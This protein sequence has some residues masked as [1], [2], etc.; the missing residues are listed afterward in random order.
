MNKILNNKDAKTQRSWS[1]SSSLFPLR[2]FAS[3]LFICL[4]LG[5]SGQT[6]TP[7]LFPLI[8]MFGSAQY[9]TPFTIQTTNTSTTD[10]S[11]LYVGQA[12]TITPQGTNPVVLL[13]PNTYQLIF[14]DGLFSVPFTVPAS[15]NTL[16]V[17]TLITN[18]LTSN[19]NWNGSFALGLPVGGSNTA[20]PVNGLGL[21]A[22]GLLTEAAWPSGGGGGGGAGT[23]T[24]AIGT[25]AMAP[26]VSGPTVFVPTNFVSPS[27]AAALIAASN[28]LTHGLCI[29]T[30]KVNY[31]A[32]NPT[33]WLNGIVPRRGDTAFVS[34][35]IYTNN[36]E[37]QGNI[38]AYM[39]IV[40]DTARCGANFRN[41]IFYDYAIND[42]GTQ[43][44][45]DRVEFRDFAQNASVFYGVVSFWDNSESSESCGWDVSF[46]NNS[47]GDY[48]YGNAHFY[49]KQIFYGNIYGD[50]HFHDYSTWNGG[51][52]GNYI[53]GN[54]YFY[55]QS[56][57]LS[58]AISN[59]V[60]Y[61][62]TGNLAN[63]TNLPATSV[64]TNGSPGAA[65]G[66][67]L[68]FNGTSAQWSNAPAGG[69]GGTVYS[70]TTTFFTGLQIGTPLGGTNG[71]TFVSG[72]G[73]YYPSWLGPGYPPVNLAS[74]W[75]NQTTH[76]QYNVHWSMNNTRYYEAWVRGTNAASSTN[77]TL[78]FG[79]SPNNGAILYDA[80][81]NVHNFQFHTANPLNSFP[82][83]NALLNC[84]SNG[85]FYF[86]TLKTG[87][88][89]VGRGLESWTGG[90]N[91]QPSF[92]QH[93]YGDG[94]S[95]FGFGTNTVSGLGFIVDTANLE[96][97]AMYF[98]PAPAL[99]TLAD[100]YRPMCFINNFGGGF[101]GLAIRPTSVA[102][103]SE[104]EIEDANSNRLFAVNGAGAGQPGT[105]IFSGGASNYVAFSTVEKSDGLAEMAFG[106]NAGASAVGMWFD[107]PNWETPS[108]SVGPYG[109]L[110]YLS[111]GTRAMFLLDNWQAG[112]DG[113]AIRPL[114]AV[115]AGY[116]AIIVNDYH[117]NLLFSVDSLGTATAQAI[118]L[119]T[120]A[121]ATTI[122]SNFVYTGT[123]VASNGLIVAIG[124]T[125]EIGMADT[126]G[127]GHISYLYTSTNSGTPT[128]YIHGS[129]SQKILSTRDFYVIMI[130]QSVA[131]VTIAIS[132]II[133]VVWYVRRHVRKHLNPPMP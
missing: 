40:A 104:L 64:T 73:T 60:Y 109:T 2:V 31:D 34:A 114:N 76:D 111:D 78:L 125:N 8:Q 113:L 52:G 72:G 121:N 62:Y 123:A 98:G 42:G 77:Y 124:S 18:G 133:H 107:T 45:N 16:N 129:G 100:G 51:G 56:T 85:C 35:N 90:T 93:V 96:N 14:Q 66:M 112:F 79:D 32:T 95:S 6:Q 33:N 128:L 119:G 71:A 74:I 83:G 116:N 108:I 122:R 97:S 25:N 47:S 81:D 15:S 19:T 12:L 63:A 29:W 94:Y 99:Y 59:H 3:L 4:G 26:S 48:V 101:E 65:T 120:N 46:H 84:P 117:S 102:S 126:N 11:F 44:T 22:S 67:F 57:N 30:G 87:D 131:S 17:L 82:D 91:P 24:N 23:L 53:Q 106:T 9:A 54:A 21:D 49:D 70:N 39:T 86:N 130:I 7:V 75:E 27:V 38:N 55:D 28:S 58:G 41:A 92:V 89:W 69:G 132:A 13:T 1:S 68:A 61:L 43:D 118:I 36:H 110:Q 127:L 115:G 50:A 88:S 103:G 80:Y 5:A 20:S 37:P 10:G 105:T